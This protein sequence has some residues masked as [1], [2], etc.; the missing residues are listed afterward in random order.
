MKG[1]IAILVMV[2]LLLGGALLVRHNKAVEQHKEDESNILRLSN[3][4]V[5]VSANFAEQKKVNITL[6]TNL[7][8]RTEELVTVSNR[9]V[10]V[11]ETLARTGTRIERAREA[12]VPVIAERARK[13]TRDLDPR[14]VPAHALAPE[15]AEG[16]RRRR[17]DV[18]SRLV[19]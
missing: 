5:Q 6:E 8:E 4:W 11:S 12:Q 16:R 17:V 9:L 10:S 3:E 18:R 13:A 7:T 1:V 19:A 14:R 2:S 15:R